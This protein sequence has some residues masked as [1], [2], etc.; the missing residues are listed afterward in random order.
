MNEIIKAN[1]AKKQAI[2]Q[3][4]DASGEAWQDYAREFVKCYCENHSEVF[5]DDIWQAGL[6]KPVSPRA[7][8]AVMQYAIREGW[9]VP[10]TRDY[11]TLARPSVRSNM[12]LKA[13]YRS[14]LYR[15]TQK[16]RFIRSKVI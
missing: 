8:G 9:I 12:Q 5:C 1:E 7:F 13:V 10:M 6:V 14:T 4:A 15:P 3:S 2:E 16:W 11:Y